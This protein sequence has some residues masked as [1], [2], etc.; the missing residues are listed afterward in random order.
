VNE[1]DAQ[2]LSPLR[3]KVLEIIRQTFRP[4][5]LELAAPHKMDKTLSYGG[6]VTNCGVFPGWLARQLHGTGPIFKVGK[7][8]EAVTCPMTAWDD[9]A[10][11]F[12]KKT[13]RSI[14]TTYQANGSVR[15]NLGDI[16]ILL[17][18]DKVKFAHVGVF[19]KEVKED[20]ETYWVTADC[21]QGDNGTAAAYRKRKFKNAAGSVE[22]IL[23]GNALPP[24]KGLRYVKGWVD[25]EKLW[26]NWPKK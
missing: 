13:G 5:P 20:S 6:G 10:E 18:P 24:D 17:K 16:Y 8:P 25:I 2:G 9:Y 19:I 22:L 26:P 11:R 21:G 3:Q 1:N 12:E 4:Y 15:P 7:W 23:G 14:W